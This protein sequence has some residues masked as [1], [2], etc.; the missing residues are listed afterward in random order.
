MLKD[1]ENIEMVKKSQHDMKELLAKMFDHLNT[2][3]I[4]LKV[5]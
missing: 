4:N 5:S 1:Y 2:K 3:D